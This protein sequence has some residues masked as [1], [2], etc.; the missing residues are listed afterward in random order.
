MASYETS[1]AEVDSAINEALDKGSVSQATADAI[2]TIVNDIAVSG[3]AVTVAAPTQNIDSA[4]VAEI[5]KDSPVVMMAKDTSADVTFDAN[6]SVKAMVVG[7]A[8]NSKVAFETSDNVTVQLQGGENDEITTGDGKDA[9]TFAGGSATIN[10]GGG[11]DEVILQGGENGGHATIQGGDGNMIVTVQADNVGASIDAGDGFDAVSM[12][13]TRTGFSLDFM[14]DAVQGVFRMVRNAITG[15]AEDAQAARAGE[16]NAIVMKDVNVVQF[17]KDA[18]ATTI[19]EITVL[20][21]T[22]GEATV[23]KLYAVALGREAIDGEVGVNANLDGLSYWLGAVNEKDAILDNVYNALL[24]CPEFAD[25]YGAMDGTQFANAMFENLAKVGEVDSVAAIDGMSAADLAARIDSGELS[26]E[27]A[28]K[29]IAQ[30]K[31]A[32]DL[33]GNSGTQYVID[34]YSQPA[35]P[36]DP[37][38]P[39]AA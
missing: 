21:D 20:A 13:G 37:T 28:A 23:A 38:E 17:T 35:E 6:S 32:A 9:V 18:Q 10:T 2:K 31:T 4:N 15:Q 22:E 25:K 33:L 19:D 39:P 3:A 5:V 29:L 36:V 12:A 24:A 8:G 34:G 26:L 7:G 11:D 14:F 30:S 27:N 1:A 16:D